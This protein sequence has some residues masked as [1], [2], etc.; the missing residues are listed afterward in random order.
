MRAL[1]KLFAF[2]KALVMLF[3]AFSTSSSSLMMCQ[4]QNLTDQLNETGFIEIVTS[5]TYRDM[6]GYFVTFK[7]D[8]DVSAEFLYKS[9]LVRLPL[10]VY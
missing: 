5:P 6:I 1:I 10:F 3:A 9:L 8:G 4:G 2:P 7:I